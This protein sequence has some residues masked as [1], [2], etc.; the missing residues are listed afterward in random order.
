MQLLLYIL[1]ICIGMAHFIVLLYTIRFHRLAYEAEL[2]DDRFIITEARPNENGSIK[3]LLYFVV[4]FI[5]AIQI[6]T[7]QAFSFRQITDVVLTITMWASLL[8]V[9]GRQGEN[10][11][12][13]LTEQEK[14]EIASE[15]LPQSYIQAERK[16]TALRLAS[17]LVVFA[18]F[19]IV[20]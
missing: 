12:D 1:G 8:H 4:P 18:Y 9:V 10:S 20:F 3:I 15:Y 16:V 7:T 13:P 2:P 6:N 11:K 14:A 5:L 17:A 19:V